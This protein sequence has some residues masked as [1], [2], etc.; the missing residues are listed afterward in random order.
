MTDW[1]DELE[2]LFKS[3]RLPAVPSSKDVS[4]LD[5]SDIELK[6]LPLDY[7][8][9]AYER[10]HAHSTRAFEFYTLKDESLT[11]CDSGMHQFA[12]LA[13][14]KRGSHGHQT[15]SRMMRVCV[16]QVFIFMSVFFVWVFFCFFFW[17]IH[18]RS[19]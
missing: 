10:D 13:Y 3:D 12:S 15:I 4:D 7:L 16:G 17:F 2:E 8:D 6:L 14:H 11:F 1:S 19:S 18:V 5:L 9:S